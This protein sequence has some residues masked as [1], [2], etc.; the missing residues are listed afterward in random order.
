MADRD[1]LMQLQGFSLVTAQI[2]YNMPDHLSILQEFIWQDYDMVPGLPKLQ[3]F[4]DFWQEKL[5]GPIHS[6]TVEHRRIISPAEF[7]MAE[8]LYLH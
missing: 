4:L 2:T 8:E 6:V 3:G 1:F 5:D 7:R